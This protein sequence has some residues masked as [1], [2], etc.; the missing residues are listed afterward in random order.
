MKLG[1]FSYDLLKGRAPHA[2]VTVVNMK[3]LFWDV[4]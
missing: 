1:S 3:L 4:R 2:A